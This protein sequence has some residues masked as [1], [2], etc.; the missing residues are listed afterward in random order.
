MKTLTNV[1]KH[2]KLFTM[3]PP[4]NLVKNEAKYPVVG[5]SHWVLLKNGSG[6]PCAHLDMYIFS[7]GAGVESS[8]SDFAKR[9][10][11]YLL[12]CVS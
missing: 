11:Q 9:I 6:F 10:F 7:R 12:I 1:S 4:F 3:S 2:S 5:D 8:I